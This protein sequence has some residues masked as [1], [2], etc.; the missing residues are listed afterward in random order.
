MDNKTFYFPEGPDERWLDV[1]LP[2]QFCHPPPLLLCLCIF[3]SL[4]SSFLPKLSFK[5]QGSLKVFT[6][7]Y[8]RLAILCVASIF[9]PLKLL[10]AQITITSETVIE[11]T[12]ISR[13]GQ[14]I[15]IKTSDNQ[16]TDALISTNPKQQSVVLNNGPR[17]R[18]PVTSQ[19]SGRLALDLTHVHI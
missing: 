17:L 8:L 16:T 12:V 14:N 1:I 10:P 15:S 18:A 3:N 7:F 13:S 2:F 9:L 6:G 11:C 5:L 4:A 19:I